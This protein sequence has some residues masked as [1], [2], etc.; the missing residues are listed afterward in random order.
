MAQSMAIAAAFGLLPRRTQV[1][2][3]RLEECGGESLS[4]VER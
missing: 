3:W 1:F 2:L 4:L